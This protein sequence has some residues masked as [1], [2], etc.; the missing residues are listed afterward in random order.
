MEISRGG[1]MGNRS[2][3]WGN[4]KGFGLRLLKGGTKPGRT[5][6]AD[7]P[8]PRGSG[9]WVDLVG[10]GHHGGAVE[11]P[12]ASGRLST[13][14]QGAC[15]EAAGE[16]AESPDRP[17]EEPVS[18][19][20]APR[21]FHR[22][23]RDRRAGGAGS[24]RAPP[25]GTRV[26]P[27]ASGVDDG[28]LR[29]RRFTGISRRSPGVLHRWLRGLPPLPPRPRDGGPAGNSWQ[30]TRGPHY[31]T[32]PPWRRSRRTSIC[33]PAAASAAIPFWTRSTA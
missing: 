21:G 28:A 17:R 9:D 23:A 4:W 6:P 31:P 1:H 18:D 8:S 25:V 33:L 16:G 13:A 29:S 22:R 27:R 2:S 19:P 3:T 5:P 10:V 30:T 11:C 32:C 7:A 26:V 15:G 12:S 14:I 20:R 24:V